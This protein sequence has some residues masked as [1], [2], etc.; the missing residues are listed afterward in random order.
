MD[1]DSDVSLVENDKDCK[2][3]LNQPKRL[4]PKRFEDL[5]SCNSNCKKFLFLFPIFSLASSTYTN[6][7]YIS[8]AALLDLRSLWGDSMPKNNIT[9]RKMS[10]ATHTTSNWE[11][12]PQNALNNATNYSRKVY[13]SFT[14]ISFPLKSTHDLEALDSVLRTNDEIKLQMLSFLITIGG[15]TRDG[16]KL[17]YILADAVFE[18]SLLTKYSWTGRLVPMA[19]P[20][21]PF[22]FFEGIVG[23]FHEAVSRSDRSYTIYKTRRFFRDKILKFSKT[24]CLRKR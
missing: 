10:N 21:K 22:Q 18:P 13:T 17:A 15:S 2:P 8:I 4:I 14:D 9:I 1:S 7:L 5:T 20:K 23:I 16:T 3:P 19:V 24:R 6:I 12:S 11:S